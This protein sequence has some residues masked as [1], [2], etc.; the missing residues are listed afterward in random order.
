MT[1]EQLFWSLG[2]HMGTIGCRRAIA[3]VEWVLENEDRLSHLV[4]QVYTPIACQY[5]CTWKA[6]ERS[7]R[8]VIRRAC[9]Q[10]P[11]L[12]NQLAGYPL[13]KP[14]KAGEFLEMVYTYMSRQ[15]VEV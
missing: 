3:V 15:K 12:M 6:V 1:T 13:E 2:V 10:N 7:L 11:D 8:T 14:P 4:V 9:K 5:G